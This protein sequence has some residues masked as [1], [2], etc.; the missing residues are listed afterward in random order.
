MDST[1]ITRSYLE[2]L[3]TQELLS[4]ADEYGIDIP[5]DLNRRFVIGELLE[6]A[7]EMNDHQPETM[8]EA[9]ELPDQTELPATYNETTITA[10]LRNPVWCYVYWDIREADRE[11][12][13]HST[14]FASL[15]LKISFF[16]EADAVKATES[17]EVSVSLTDK[18]QYV[19]IPNSENYFR[20]DLVA[21]YKNQPAK[22][23]AS[24]RVLTIPKGCAELEMGTAAMEAEV[25]PVLKL[26]G[27][28]E[29]IR[30]HYTN[31]RQSFS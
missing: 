25:P 8:Q 23:L 22:L 20:I 3:S 16:P 14:S 7:E 21:E 4:L 11:S 12:L 18:D 24:S 10:V 17:F 27:F 15:K 6:A 31:Y 13:S 5:E 30:S 9:G 26:S 19:F 28:P 1:C 2:T 29:L